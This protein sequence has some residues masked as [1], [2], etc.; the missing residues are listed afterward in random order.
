MTTTS[1]SVSAVVE[2]FPLIIPEMVLGAFGCLMFVGATFRSNRHVWGTAALAG[3]L[4]AGAW[5][6]F[7]PRPV[8]FRSFASPVVLDQLA[9]FTKFLAI[10]G[11]VVLVLLS[12]NEVPDPYAAEFHGCLL[13]IVAGLC[14]TGAANELITLF[15][16]LELISIP[17]YVLLYLPR[18]DDAAQEASMK[19]FLLSV[20]SSA[21]LLFGF[22]YLFGIGGTTNLPTIV[23]SLT[24]P[25]EADRSHAITVVA[26]IMVVAGL[27]Y[28]IAAVPF[29]Y[30]A[31]R[32]LSRCPDQR[33][34]LCS[35]SYQRW[36]A[37]SR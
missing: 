22:S 31:A 19:Y 17:T 14:L 33:A 23:E 6:L 26:V 18:F 30:Y 24:N 27:G 12:W 36:P 8:V 15:L 29:H 1:A 20:F 37:S 9:L 16:A 10:F 3:L 2:A 34:R 5:L 28:K 21:L 32:C 13:I 35:R 11:G 4:I 25:D 7:S